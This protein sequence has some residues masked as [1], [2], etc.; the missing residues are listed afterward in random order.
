M[1]ASSQPKWRSAAGLR[2]SSLFSAIATGVCCFFVLVGIAGIIARFPR[3]AQLIG[4]VGAFSYGIYL[5]H[6]PYVIWLGLRIREQPLWMFFLIAI[7]TL[8]VSVNLLIDGIS[9]R[10][11]TVES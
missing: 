6:H 10:T 7:A 9:G 2:K 11:R 1:S 5:V 3:P 8:T 4:L